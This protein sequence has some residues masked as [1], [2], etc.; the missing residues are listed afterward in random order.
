M[1]DQNSRP[2]YYYGPRAVNR[3]AFDEDS[4]G[5]QDQQNRASRYPEPGPSVSYPITD[6]VSRTISDCLRMD[7]LLFQQGQ[8][9]GQGSNEDQTAQQEHPINQGYYQPSDQYRDQ[10][11]DQQHDQHQDQYHNQHNYQLL[12]NSA[13]HPMATMPVPPNVSSPSDL[14]SS[15]Q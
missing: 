13:M 4:D 10:H 3:T 15:S 14:F 11:Q 1:D 12:I 7:G 8:P 6:L 9:H 2:Y 5:G